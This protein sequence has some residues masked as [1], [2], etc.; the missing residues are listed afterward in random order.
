MWIN[1]DDDELSLYFNYNERTEHDTE[2]PTAGTEDTPI[3]HIRGTNCR[4]C[5]HYN[6][7]MN[8][9]FV[10]NDG[11]H[12]CYNCITSPYRWNKNIPKDRKALLKKYY[13]DILKKYNHYNYNY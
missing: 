3:V 5:D 4:V 1:D 8:A 11:K 13:K 10:A 7:Y 9:D 6:H 2:P 12:T